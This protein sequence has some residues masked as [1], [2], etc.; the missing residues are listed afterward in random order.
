MQGLTTDCQPLYAP[1]TFDT[2][3]TKL[4]VPTCASGTGTCHTADAA[5]GG[6]VFATADDAYS[7]LVGGGRVTPGDPSCSLIM[8]RITSTD[9]SYH[10][11]P[12][13]VSLSG[14]EE[15]AI[16]QWIAGGAKR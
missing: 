7:R 9:P 4:F 3:Y 6:L 15:C 11:P 1:P 10:M 5:K 12:G 16:V 8:K 14:P 13:T 2:L